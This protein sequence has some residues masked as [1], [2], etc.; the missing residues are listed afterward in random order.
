LRGRSVRREAATREGGSS[1]SDR[2]LI[3]EI[4]RAQGLKGEVRLR[5][6]AGEPGAI[7]GYGPLED[8]SGTRRFEIERLRAD[9][10]GLVAHVKGID[11]REA[12]E[13]LTGTKLYVMRA[14]L[15][16]AAEEEWYHADLIGLE[17]RGAD[18]GSIGTLVG[19][20]NFGASDVIEIA[21]LGGGPTILVAFTHDTVPDVDVDA[22][23]LRVLLPEAME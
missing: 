23:W 4:G 1:K 22:G 21:P 6:Y 10:K 16:N 9:G 17:A 20:H 8:E 7:A 11:T 14:A 15:P 5:S 19:V 18:G 13:A 2:L 3:G 12:A